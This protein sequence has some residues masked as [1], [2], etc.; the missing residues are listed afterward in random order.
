[1]SN[2][3]IIIRADSV[4]E[5]RSLQDSLGQESLLQNAPPVNPVPIEAPVTDTTQAPIAP[6]NPAPGEDPAG[7]AVM[8][9]GLVVVTAAE[10]LAFAEADEAAANSTCRETGI[11]G[12][13]LKPLVYQ[14]LVEL[15]KD[16]AGTVLDFGAGKN[17]VHTKA[18]KS[19]GWR[20]VAW[21]FGDNF[22][23]G[24]HDSRALDRKYDTVVASNV[25]NVQQS[26]GMLRETLE[27]LTSAVKPGGT[28]ICNMPKEPRHHD[29]SAEDVERLL[30]RAGFEVEESKGGSAPVWV[31]TRGSGRSAAWPYE[32]ALKSDEAFELLDRE[33]GKGCDWM[34]GGCGVL[35]ETLRRRLGGDLWMVVDNGIPQHVVLKKGDM[36]FDRYGPKSEERML[37][38][39]QY[40][41]GLKQPHLEP[42]DLDKLGEIPWRT[43]R[44]PAELTAILDQFMAGGGGRSAAI[45]SGGV[46]WTGSPVAGIEQFKT[47][48]RPHTSYEPVEVPMFL[49][50]DKEFARAHAVGPEGT[51]YQVALTPG[52]NLFDSDD[53]WLGDSQ[54]W[55]PEDEALTPLG[56]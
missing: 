29:V 24:V 6:S 4:D 36:F 27:Q 37:R 22:V 7:G 14:K 55:P 16:R 12:T 32:E 41:E 48:T 13:P 3:V 44:A 1:M 52:L 30:G 50:R 34:H 23:K 42:V 21:E 38:A 54:Y 28:L 56:R 47:T 49:T 33:V 26:K 18:L 39:L 35:A 2:D 45:D 51:L 5:L 53:L 8:V 19:K 9:A 20:V 43:G 10:V 25:L 17:A 40:E 46:W 11:I 15:G 31:F